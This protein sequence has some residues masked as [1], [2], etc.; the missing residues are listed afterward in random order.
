M[1]LIRNSQPKNRSAAYDRL[2]GIPALGSLISRRPFIFSTH[3]AN[4]P[5]LATP[6]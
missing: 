3:N 4:I 1:A 5:C 2:F 6:N